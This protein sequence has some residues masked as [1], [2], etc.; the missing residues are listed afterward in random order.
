MALLFFSIQN[1]FRK[2]AVAALAVLGVAF[3][4]ALMTILF[5]L[6]GGMDHRVEGTFSELANRVTI[7]GRDAI[8]GGL[9]LG[10]GTRPIPSSYIDT[11]RNIPHV[12]KV[13]SQV[14]VVMRPQNMDYVMPLFGY[15][16]E[17]IHDLDNNP[18]NRIIEGAAPSNEKE[19]IIGKSL[20]EYMS[21]LNFHYAI[22]NSYP[23]I[24]MEGDR[25][26]ELDVKIVGV[27]QTGNEVLDGA[28]SGSEKLAR[29]IGKIP[30]GSVSAI[31]VAVDG[32][33][34]VESTAKAIQQELSGKKPELQVVV[35]GEVL[36]P[37]RN[38][39][40]V[41]G[42]F[43]MAVSLVAVVAGGLSIMVVMLLSV[44]NRMREFGILKA[45]GWTPANIVFMVLVESLALSLLGAALGVALGCAGLAVARVLIAE[46][47][48]ALS[49]QVTVSVLA[50]GVL[51]GVA[52]GIYPAWRANSAAPVKILREI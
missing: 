10:M 40:D 29:E 27:Y 5:S 23:F 48:A 24:I 52:G 49:W 12:E 34:N 11:I 4:T 17:E 8:F 32:V 14:S 19:I 51:I 16:T 39:L 3:G 42:K 20:Q 22:G 2:K 38:I 44:I 33:E 7:S 36:N 37:V 26:K 25:A 41:L 21:L 45:L 30:E 47:I 1:A 50:A 31:N 15:D 9:Y 18:Y 6:A 46:D 28:F 43:L 13:Y 35:P